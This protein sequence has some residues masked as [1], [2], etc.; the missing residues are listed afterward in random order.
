[1]RQ[2]ALWALVELGLPG[3]EAVL[4]SIR[5]RLLDDAWIVRW[6]ALQALAQLRRSDAD[7]L[8]DVQALLQDEVE[9]VRE[10]A[11]QTLAKIARRSKVPLSRLPS[12]TRDAM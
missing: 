11:A 8:T 1:M 4:M 5:Q 12:A 7:V 10:E 6:W 2:A 9:A 3:D